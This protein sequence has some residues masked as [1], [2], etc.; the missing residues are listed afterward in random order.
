MGDIADAALDGT[1]CQ[2]C[3][4]LVNTDPPGHPVTCEECQAEEKED[5]VRE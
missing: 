4:E 3:G 2:V 1:L 5:V